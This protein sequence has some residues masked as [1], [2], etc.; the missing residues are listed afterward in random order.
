MPGV[1]SADVSCTTGTAVCKVEKGTSV[2]ALLQAIGSEG[3]DAV[4]KN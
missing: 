2:D 1:V 4:P 3:F